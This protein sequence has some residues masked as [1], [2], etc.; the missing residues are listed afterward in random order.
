MMSIL[1]E[2]KDKRENELIKSAELH[3]LYDR[4]KNYGELVKQMHKPTISRRKQIEL[5]VQKA[6]LKHIPKIKTLEAIHSEANALSSESQSKRLNSPNPSIGKSEYRGYFSENPFIKPVRR[7]KENDMKPSPKKKLLPKV[8]DYL[9]ER[10]IHN[11]EKSTYGDYEPKKQHKPI[12]WKTLVDK[13]SHKDKFEFLRVKA[14]Q[15]EE[16]AKLQDQKNNLGKRNF[17]LLFRI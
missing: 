14:E 3:D 4:R 5:K 1:E 16:K 11:E 9:L 13:M 17:N 6:K 15:I 7:W 8:T 10:R 12:E 2:E